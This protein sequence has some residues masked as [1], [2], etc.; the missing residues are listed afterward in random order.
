MNAIHSSLFPG[1]PAGAMCGFCRRPLASGRKDKNFCSRKCRQSAFRIRRRQLTD[2]KANTVKFVAYADPPYPGRADKFY[3]DEDSF[4]GE[5]DHGALID[6][7]HSNFDGWA[8]STSASTLREVLPLCPDE[9]RV[10]AWVKP[11]GVSSRTY[12]AHNTWEPL[13]V[14]PGRR[15]RPGKRDWLSAMPARGNGTLM[16]RKPIAFC[17]FLFQMLGMLAGD[18]LTDV[19]PGTGIVGNAWLEVCHASGVQPAK[20][21]IAV[22]SFTPGKPMDIDGTGNA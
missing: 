10:C 17:A 3:A 11:I 15:L 18:T 2:D 19:F 22:P 9:A 21:D 14:V 5:V 16:G 13:I 6:W 12:G 1:Q 8:L 7:L 20:F 4:A